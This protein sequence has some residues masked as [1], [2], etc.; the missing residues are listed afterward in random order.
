M[1]KKTEVN[2]LEITLYDSGDIGFM[3]HEEQ[4]SWTLSKEEAEALKKLLSPN[5]A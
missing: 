1:I 5:E 3:D 4:T 2:T